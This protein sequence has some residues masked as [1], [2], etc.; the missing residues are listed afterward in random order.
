MKAVFNDTQVDKLLPGFKS[1]LTHGR[2]DSGYSI[3]RISCCCNMLYR[4]MQMQLSYVIIT[5]VVMYNRVNL[6]LH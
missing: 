6:I 1:F 4:G 5:L 2:S 3:K